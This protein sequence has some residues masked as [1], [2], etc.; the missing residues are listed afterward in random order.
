MT[1]TETVSATTTN[2]MLSG[3]GGQGIITLSAILSRACLLAGL[4]VKKSEVHGMSQ[5]G[6]SVESHVRF[7]PDEVFSPLI[8]WGGADIVVALERV[9]AVRSADWCRP[10]GVIITDERK[11]CPTTVSSGPFEYPEDCR[12]QLDDIEADVVLINAFDIASELGEP[13]AANMVMLGAMSGLLEIPEKAYT[14]AMEKIIKKNAVPINIEAF[15][16]GRT[17][18]G[19]QLPG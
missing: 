5:R 17:L 2:I 16:R 7:S 6:G 10:G 13:R 9:E 14:E 15:G 8:P 11:I 19:E 18:I 12:E 3:V 4:N 1:E